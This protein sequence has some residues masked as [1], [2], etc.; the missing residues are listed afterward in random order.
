MRAIVE[1][2]YTEELYNEEEYETLEKVINQVS[3]DFM[4]QVFNVQQQVEKNEWMVF[5][6]NPACAW[7]FDFATIREKVFK[8]AGIEMLHINENESQR[9]FSRLR[10]R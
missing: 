9:L 5:S 6:H 10:D 4:Q 2:G 1:V 3:Q 8:A 7:L